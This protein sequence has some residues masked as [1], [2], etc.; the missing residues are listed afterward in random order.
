MYDIVAISGGGNVSSSNMYNGGLNAVM[1][2]ENNGFYEKEYKNI[3]L[4][5]GTSLK[6]SGVKIQLIPKQ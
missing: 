3:K 6:V 2:T 1:G 5:T 4:P